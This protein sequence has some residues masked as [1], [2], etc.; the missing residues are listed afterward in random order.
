MRES[1]FFKVY[2]KGSKWITTTILPGIALVFIVYGIRWAGFEG[3]EMV[4][5]IGIGTAMLG[6]YWIGQWDSLKNDV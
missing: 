3:G 6:V 1:K 2:F 5:S 4:F